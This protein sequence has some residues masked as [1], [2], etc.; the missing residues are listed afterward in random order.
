MQV[1]VIPVTPFQQNCS[2]VICEQSK[3]G[4]VID[5]GGELDKV[6]A[7][8]AQEGVTVE[9]ILITH[10]HIDHAGA[11]AELAAE[12]KVPVVGPQREDEFLI[13]ALAEHGAMFGVHGA[14]PFTPDQWLEHGDVVEVGE[15]RFEVRHCPGHTPGHVIFFNPLR[16]FALVGDMLFDGSVGR[17][18]LPRG[19]H[20]TMM[21]S[22][23]EQIL[24]L[25]DDTTF[26]SGHGPTSTI[27]AQRHSNPFLRGL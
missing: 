1:G 2:V 23:R 24:T 17:T 26:L 16:K 15:E 19:D 11:T 18:D 10:G 3:R 12:L 13:Q 22:L 8:L 27:G 14:Q 7:F 25:P 9:K 20:A 6:R 21:V 4:A 5:P